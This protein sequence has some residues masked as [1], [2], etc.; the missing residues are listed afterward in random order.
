MIPIDLAALNGPTNSTIDEFEFHGCTCGIGSFTGR[1]PWECHNGGDELL[2]VLA[3][4]SEL[5]VLEG[6]RQVS[7]AI[8]TGALVVVPRGCWPN[9]HPPP[10]PTTLSLTPPHTTTHPSQ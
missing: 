3:G 4:E 7:Q 1:P 5:T 9:T 2:L 8:T 10:R 6:A